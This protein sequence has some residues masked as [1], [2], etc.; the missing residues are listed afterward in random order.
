M[1][2]KQLYEQSLQLDLVADAVLSGGVIAYPTEGVWGLGCNPMDEVAVNRV[3]QL[4]QRPAS[5]GLILVAGS[6]D[7]FQ[8][9]LVEI[10]DFPAMPGPT[11][12][13][14]RHGGLTPEWVSGG[15][16]KVAI[17]V[18]QHPLIMAICAKVGMPI[19][20]T[21][22]NPSSME[23]ASSAEQV[24]H[25]FGDLVDVIVP[26]SLGG[27]SGASQIIDWETKEVARGPAA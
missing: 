11:T 24:R 1:V 26:G 16:E 8:Q 15:R 23:P 20:S 14:V 18:S 7:Q 22:A 6:R 9:C 21:S 19:V 10:P 5:K 2:A 27:A 4:K 13:L 3:L 17:R 25:Y 12:W